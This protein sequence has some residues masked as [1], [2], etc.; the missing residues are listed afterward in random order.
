M[1]AHATPGVH[2]GRHAAHCRP[3]T[4]DHECTLAARKL[5]SGPRVH[6]VQRVSYCPLTLNRLDSE[7]DVP[8]SPFAEMV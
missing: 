6:F 8:N 3:H 4:R 2:V 5:A 1:S 7:V